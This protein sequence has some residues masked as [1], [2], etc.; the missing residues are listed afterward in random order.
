MNSLDNVLCI[1]NVFLQSMLIGVSCSDTAIVGKP[2]Y[3]LHIL[4]HNILH[5]VLVYTGIYKL[6]FA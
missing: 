5:I 2:E 1:P 6:R 4:S 3:K